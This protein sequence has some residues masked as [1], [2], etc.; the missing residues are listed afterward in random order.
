MR[1]RIIIA[2]AVLFIGACALVVFIRISSHYSAPDAPAPVPVPAVF[3]P[4]ASATATATTPARPASTPRP[5]H[6]ITVWTT[7]PARTSAA[8]ED[9]A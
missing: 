5:T 7:V 1:D 3:T 2:L 6:T 4:A 8:G 9:G